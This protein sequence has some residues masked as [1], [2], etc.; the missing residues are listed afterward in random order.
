MERLT[1]DNDGM[2]DADAFL[3]FTSRL[4]GLRARVD[5]ASVSDQQRLRWQRKLIAV[6]DI[7]AK[8]LERASSQLTRFEAEV[9]RSIGR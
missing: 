7:G 4:K 6:S 2:L 9:D 5:A 3:E 1:P 8:D